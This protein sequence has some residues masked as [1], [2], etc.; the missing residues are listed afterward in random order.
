MY[1]FLALPTLKSTRIT[2]TTATTIAMTTMIATATPTPIPTLR[3]LLDST[4]AGVVG[5]LVG[6]C[7]ETRQNDNTGY[8]I[9]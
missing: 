1:L 6:A 2:T 9:V 3:L 4:S 5:V 7:G 8:S